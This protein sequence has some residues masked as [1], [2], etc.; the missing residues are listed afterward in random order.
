MPNTLPRTSTKSS[1]TPQQV[2][3]LKGQLTEILD[4]SSSNKSYEIQVDSST[5]KAKSNLFVK[6]LKT[7]KTRQ[8]IETEQKE[9]SFKIGQELKSRQ[10]L[11]KSPDRDDF[12]LV[13]TSPRS[14]NDVVKATMESWKDELDDERPKSVNEIAKSFEDKSKTSTCPPDSPSPRFQ[15]PVNVKEVKH[16]YE[17]LNGHHVVP[18]MRSS[19][20]CKAIEQGQRCPSLGKLSKSTSSLENVL[21]DQQNLEFAD[22][23]MSNPDIPSDTEKKPSWNTSYLSPMSPLLHSYGAYGQKTDQDQG[24]P[25]KKYSRAYLN[26]VKT[27]SVTNKLS[28]FENPNVPRGYSPKTLQTVNKKAEK[29]KDYVAKHVTDPKKVI[30]KT[31]EVGN[32][33]DTVKRLEMKAKSPVPYPCD[34]TVDVVQVPVQP[35]VS[36]TWTDQK[37]KLKHFCKKMSHSKILNKM[38]ALQ[39]ASQVPLDKGTEKLLMKNNQE[40]VLRNVYQSGKVE[41]KVDMFEK[42]VARPQSPA[43]VWATKTESSFSWAKRLNPADASSL[44]QKHNQ[45][46]KYYGYHPADQTKLEKRQQLQQP[47]S[48]PVFLENLPPPP[49]IR[50]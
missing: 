18:P 39:C 2:N 40:E 10:C 9:L 22:V 45:F 26:L 19:S 33:T 23:S 15:S 37:A 14:N 24:E 32:V 30:I 16:S 1:L 17:K 8:E 27:G 47:T 35:K 42:P 12:L 6:P 38:I 34:P 25:S 50:G 41:S 21:D 28:K 49:P 11:N 31:K 13:L 29:V 5:V 4:H 43:P 48:L 44:A 36:L 7:K 46:R 3:H 20:F